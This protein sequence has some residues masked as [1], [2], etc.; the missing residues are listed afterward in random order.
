MDITNNKGTVDEVEK[1]DLKGIG[2]SNAKRRLELLYP[3]KYEL[4]IRDMESEFQVELKL[5]LS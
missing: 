4:N 5:D 2:L 1:N 3:G